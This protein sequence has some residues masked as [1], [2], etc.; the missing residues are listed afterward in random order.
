MK[1]IE[2]LKKAYDNY[3]KKL[4]KINQEEFGKDGLD[5]CELNKDK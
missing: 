4:A 5:C 3:L 2:K 1:M